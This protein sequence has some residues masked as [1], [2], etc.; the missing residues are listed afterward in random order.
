MIIKTFTAD[1]MAAGLKLVR[2]ELGKDAVV[3]K[4]REIT[5]GGANGRVEITAC[6][7][8][9]LPTPP[10]PAKTVVTGS[11]NSVKTFTPPPVTNR[12]QATATIPAQDPVAQRLD[13]IE[14]KLNRMAA[15]PGLNSGNNEVEPIR[16]ALRYVDV[17]SEVIDA[18]VGSIEPSADISTATASLRAN[19]S[20]RISGLISSAIEFKPGD[21]VLF[22]GP[23]AAG[24][25]SALGKLAAS[26]V[27]QQKQKVTLV[28]LDSMKVGANEEIQSY[29]DIIGSPVIANDASS[30]PESD[31]ITLIDSSALPRQTDQ[32]AILRNHI[33]TLKPNYRFAVFSAVMRS[34]DIIEY[35]KT[36]N[37]FEPTH[38]ILTGLDLTDRWGGLFAACQMTNKQ[39]LFTANTPGGVGALITPDTALF[40]K[41]LLTME[42][43]RG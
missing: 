11:R 3:L 38:V 8:K 31:S 7:E 22:F 5:G 14:A 36:I 15:N 10:A 20:E 40:V 6:T 27:F 9:P 24:K 12:F 29:G 19:L 35:A 18:L 43:S 39:L 26:L 2:S 30:S 16:V 41:K 1:S 4:S 33:E 17:P 21:R 42:E 37:E 32:L 28:S 34:D 13:Q 25:T 23:A